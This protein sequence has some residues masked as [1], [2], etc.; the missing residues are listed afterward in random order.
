MVQVKTFFSDKVLAL[1]VLAVMMLCDA[2]EAL[3]QG[4]LGELGEN[5]ASNMSGLAKGVQYG[6]F[7]IGLVFAV[8]GIVEFKGVGQKPGCTVGGGVVKLGVGVC[9]LGLGA[10]LTSSSTTI[11]GSDENQGLGELGL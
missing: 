6:A 10:F 1:G 3:A 7:F 4:G 5:V 2:R 11:F 9:L 8:L